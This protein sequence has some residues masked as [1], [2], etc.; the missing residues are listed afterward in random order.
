MPLMPAF[1]LFALFGGSFSLCGVIV[2]RLAM[3]HIYI[4]YD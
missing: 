3:S 1:A 4:Y 2:A